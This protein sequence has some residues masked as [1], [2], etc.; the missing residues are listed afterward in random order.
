MSMGSVLKWSAAALWPQRV[1]LRGPSQGSRVAL[2]FDDGPHPEHTPLLL[3]VL[4]DAQVQAT[5][6]LQGSHAEQWPQLVREIHARGHQ[7]AN[8]AYSHR[9]ARQ[10]SA[11]DFVQEV[12]RTQALLEHIVGG[13]LARDFRPPFGDTT[14]H[15]FLRLARLGYRWVF[16]SLDSDDSVVRDPEQLALRTESLQAGPG[17]I[18]LFHEDYAHSVAAMPRVLASWR[19]RGLNAVRVDALNG[20]AQPGH[21][22][23]PTTQ[24]AQRP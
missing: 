24:Q 17:D 8:H 11:H 4:A 12:E 15:S 16:W 6:F 14:P 18:V 13:S 5:F 22:T 10:I 1:V 9:S 21:M 7:V 19:A 2:T 20:A 3:D 23:I